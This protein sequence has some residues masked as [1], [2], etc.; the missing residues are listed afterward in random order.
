MK[1]PTREEPTPAAKKPA[2]GMTRKAFGELLKR[3]ISPDTPKTAPKTR[4]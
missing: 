2:K 3:A 4:P 1:P